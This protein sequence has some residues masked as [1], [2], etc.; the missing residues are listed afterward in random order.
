MRAVEGCNPGR[1]ASVTLEVAVADTAQAMGSGD[2]P[3]L[4]SPRIVALAEQAAVKAMG[5]CLGEDRTSVG[6][7]VELEHLLP[8]PVGSR[9]DAEATLLGVHGR[10]LEFTVSVR[11]GDEEVAHLRHRRIVVDRSRF[12]QKV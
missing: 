7:W 5:D 3:V 2:V 12:L 9:V 11:S 1:R 4:A 6:S 10:R 8:S